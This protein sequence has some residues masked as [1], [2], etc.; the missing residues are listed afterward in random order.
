[1]EKKLFKIL[2]KVMSY[3]LVACLALGVGYS[4]GGGGGAVA[5]GS[6]PKLDEIAEIVG[7]SERQVQR[8]YKTAMTALLS[9]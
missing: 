8:Y 1:M 3:L 7:Y 5:A 9:L 2:A 6:Y 4:Y